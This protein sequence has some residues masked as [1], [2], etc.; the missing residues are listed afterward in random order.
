MKDTI[1]E[2]LKS[3]VDLVCHELKEK[4][5]SS[6][7]FSQVDG[8][9]FG[10]NGSEYF[11][12]RNSAHE[13][14]QVKAWTAR[15]DPWRAKLK[16]G[17]QIDA[18]IKGRSD[19]SNYCCPVSSKQW[20]QARIESFFCKEEDVLEIVVPELGLRTKRNR[21]SYSIAEFRSRT[22]ID[23]AWRAN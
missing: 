14:E 17:D 1:F 3:F 6:L 4:R 23:Y 11:K 21:W 10:T 7:D 12:N 9:F 19:C 13:N 20:R 2:L 18:L 22:R 8:L 5:V 15:I 16:I